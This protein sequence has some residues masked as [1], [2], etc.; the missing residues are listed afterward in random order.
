MGN[1]SLTKKMLFFGLV[2]FTLLCGS[3]ILN[4]LSLNNLQKEFETF[5]KQNLVGKIAVLEIQ[6]D[7]NYISRLTRDIMLGNAYNE[8]LEKIQTYINRIDTGFQK[9]RATLLESNQPNPQMELLERSHASTMAFVMDGFTK[10]DGLK[11]KALTPELLAQTYKNYRR[12]ATPLANES[13]KYFNEFKK[14]KDKELEESTLLFE[15]KVARFKTNLTIQSIA[16]LILILSSLLFIARNIVKSIKTFQEGL[17]GF[18]EFLNHTRSQ[19]KLIPVTSGDEIGQMAAIVNENIQNAQERIQENDAFLQEVSNFA[20]EIA[21]GNMLAKLEANPKAQ[22][23]R[24]LKE[25]LSKMQYDLEHTIARSI[26]L[27]LEV[28]ESYKKQD[29]TKRLPGAYAK[30]AVSTNSL[31]DE[32]CKMLKASKENAEALELKAKNLQ[33]QMASLSMAST[34]QAQSIKET[35]SAMIHINESI[36]AT[37]QKTQ[38]VSHQSNQIKSIIEIISDIADQTNLLALNAAIEAAR[39]GEHGR[40]FAVV[41][42]EVRNLA[43]RTQKSLGEINANISILVQSMNDIESVV[44]E[45]ASSIVQISQ[46]MEEIDENTQQNAHIAENINTIAHEV[47]RMSKEILKE[48]NRKKF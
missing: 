3:L 48:A 37:S 21:S 46:S 9:L 29:F 47:N 8:N 6:S 28:L 11:G 31:G 30:V 41:A 15:S 26:P 16:L 13:R 4:L 42:D 23:L 17:L 20:K 32:V 7:L 35:T 27:L 22:N 12:D 38:E 40:G 43:E 19:I 14:I 33:D 45:Q 1:M 36:V 10:M 25:I 34:K 2:V 44:S 18:F 5:S 24:S 39:A